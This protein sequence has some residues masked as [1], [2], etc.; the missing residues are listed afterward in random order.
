MTTVIETGE[1]GLM[2]PAEAVHGAWSLEVWL[3]A[4]REYTPNEEVDSEGGAGTCAVAAT[5]EEEAAAAAADFEEELLLQQIPVGAFENDSERVAFFYWV[6]HLSGV[7][8]AYDAACRNPYR[9]LSFLA[10]SSPLLMKTIVSLSTEYMYEQRRTTPEVTLARKNKA[11][12]LLHTSLQR[13]LSLSTT[14]AQKEQLCD[15]FGTISETQ[16]I[17]AAVLLQITNAMLVRG[18]GVE[19]HLAY[20]MHL[21]QALGYLEAPVQALLPRLLVQRFAIIDVIISIYRHTRPRLP[22]SF[23]LFVPD[24]GQDRSHPS[25][26]EMTGCPQPLLGLFARIAHLAADHEA[27]RQKAAEADSPFDAIDNDGAFNIALHASVLETDLRVFG[28]GHATVGSSK[29][30]SGVRYLDVLGEAFYWSAHLALQR[31]AQRDATHSLR[32]QA[33]VA[34]IV[35]CIRRLPVGCGPDLSVTFP[36]YVSSREALTHSHRAWVR[37]YSAALKAR[38]P[39]QLQDAMISSLEEIW[40]VTDKDRP[41]REDLIRQNDEAVRATEQ[42]SSFMF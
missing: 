1:M 20:A 36:F 5:D 34:N 30:S 39:T 31:E 21:L 15:R 10:L 2:N 3:E 41:L 37:T 11:L 35:R 7:L 40:A 26:R 19:A 13:A 24:E 32:V 17:L 12:A 18:S 25:F 14:D 27:L 42:S 9:Q 28:R 4:Q 23:W 33:A 38:Y 29:R 16:A 22:L 8:P 6:K